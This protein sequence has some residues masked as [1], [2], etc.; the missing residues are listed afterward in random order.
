MIEPAS[1]AT[2]ATTAVVKVPVHPAY[3]NESLVSQMVRQII[4]SGESNGD[5]DKAAVRIAEFADASQK[6]EELPFRWALGAEALEQIRPKITKLV[7]DM[8]KSEFWS[9]NLL[10]N[11]P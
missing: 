9:K 8:G 4:D 3:T 5:P 6:G 7:D 10:F 11:D 1:F 2:K